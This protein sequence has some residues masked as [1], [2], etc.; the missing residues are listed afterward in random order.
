MKAPDEYTIQIESGRGNKEFQFDHIFLAGSTQ[1]EIFEDTNVSS[2]ELSQGTCRLSLKMGRGDEQKISDALFQNIG[3]RSSEM[4]PLPKNGIFKL[5]CW[6]F[7]DPLNW[8]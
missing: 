5:I 3:F 8:L 1:E 6:T 2:L 4:P 7:A